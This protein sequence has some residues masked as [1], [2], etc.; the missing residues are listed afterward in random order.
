MGDCVCIMYQYIWSEAEFC[1]G[2]CFQGYYDIPAVGQ[3]CS[4]AC[5]G[6]SERESAYLQPSDLKV[7]KCTIF[8]SNIISTVYHL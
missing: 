1:W 6:H 4:A 7:G 2:M 5:G 3:E 8:K